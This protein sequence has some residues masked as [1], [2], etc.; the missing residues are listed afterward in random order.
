MNATL[1]SHSAF[2]GY[3]RSRSPSRPTRHSR[4]FGI[5]LAAALTTAARR[6]R[7]NDLGVGDVIGMGLATH[8]IARLTT[9]NP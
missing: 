8:K 9:K 6:G 5:G 1:E 7:L 2:E 3:R 4:T